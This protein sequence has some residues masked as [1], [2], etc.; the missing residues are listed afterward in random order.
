MLPVIGIGR[1]APCALLLSTRTISA[2]R[3]DP[4][5]CAAA[6]APL[7]RRVRTR[8]AGPRADRADGRGTRRP[9]QRREPRRVRKLVRGSGGGSVDLLV[10]CAGGR[11]ACR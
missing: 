5:T 2:A 3:I 11:A 4:R 1:R 8:G 10:V 7:R 6:G 9:P